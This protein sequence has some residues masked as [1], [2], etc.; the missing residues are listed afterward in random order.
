MESLHHLNQHFGTLYQAYQPIF[1]TF[2][3]A[4]KKSSNSIAISLRANTEQSCLQKMVTK[5][6]RTLS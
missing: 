4:T 3:R 6:D 2:S 1:V 5:I